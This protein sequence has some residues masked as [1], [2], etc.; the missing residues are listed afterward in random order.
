MLMKE[1]GCATLAICPYVP[2]EFR[3]KPTASWWWETELTG[4][5]AD[6]KDVVKVVWNA[7]H[8]N[9]AHASIEQ[10]RKGIG[11]KGKF[12]YYGSGTTTNAI[13]AE[14]TFNDGSIKNIP[15]SPDFQSPVDDGIHLRS[16]YRTIETGGGA[17]WFDVDLDLYAP[18]GG[19]LAQGNPRISRLRRRVDGWIAPAGPRLV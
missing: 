19:S 18:R 7:G 6:L 10:T 4:N 2:G 13:S 1:K 14:V 8:L 16:S 9:T 17:V 12:A 3:G 15:L 5:L 11:A